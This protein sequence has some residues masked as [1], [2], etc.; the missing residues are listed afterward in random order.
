VT[1]VFMVPPQF[2]AVLGHP[3][4][5][6]ADL[7]SLQVML[8]AGSA[9]RGDTKRRVPERMGPDLMELYGLTEGVGTILRPEDVT[10]KTDSVGTPA[11]GSDFRIIDNDGRELPGGQIGAIIGYS[12]GPMKW[13]HN[14]PDATREAVWIAEDGRTY[15]KTGDIG[16]LDEEGF[17]YLLD[18]KK[19]MI[20]S[21]GFNVY[22]RD[23]EE[24]AARHP[25]IADVAVIGMPDPRWDE[26]PVALVVPR[27]GTAPDPGALKEWINQ[28]V[29]KYQRVAWVAWV[30]WVAFRET[31]PRNAL[32]VLKKELRAE[33]A[34]R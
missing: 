24:V 26:V 22:P 9:V 12:T 16:K 18:R 29:A 5:E 19:D 14:R 15:L 33:Y 28:R 7:S 23:T 11:L 2:V 34:A 21:G 10:R 27:P 1:P 8:S 17:L 20:L 13:Y 30:A 3:R 4:V 32:G 25:D 31:F 6:G